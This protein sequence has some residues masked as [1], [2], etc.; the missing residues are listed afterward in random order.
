MSILTFLVLTLTLMLAMLLTNARIV[1]ERQVGVI[2][3][4]AHDADEP[5]PMQILDHNDQPHDVFIEP[6]QMVMFESEKWVS[7]WT[8]TYF[9]FSV[10]LCCRLPHGRPKPLNGNFWDNH[11]LHYKLAV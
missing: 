4:M 9:L 5:W 11:F 1:G 10:T 6:Q 2:I 3:H 8:F 7:M